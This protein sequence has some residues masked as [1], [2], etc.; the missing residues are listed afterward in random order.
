MSFFAI[1][2]DK[3]LISDYVLATLCQSHGANMPSSHLCF[4]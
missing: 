4:A 1:D 2:K 3:D